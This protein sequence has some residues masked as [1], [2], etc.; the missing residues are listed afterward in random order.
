MRGWG[1]GGGGGILWVFSCI[2]CRDAVITNLLWF[3]S[4]SLQHFS[5]RRGQDGDF[6]GPIKSYIF[7]ETEGPGLLSISPSSLF[8]AL[9]Q[10]ASVS[11]KRGDWGREGEPVSIV[12][13]TFR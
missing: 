13:N 3:T 9:S 1:K 4:G 10:W 5:K 8:Q 6:F 2:K 11:K 12:L 7:Q